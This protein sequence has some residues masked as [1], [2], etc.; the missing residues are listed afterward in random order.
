MNVPQVLACSFRGNGYYALNLVQGRKDVRRCQWND[1]LDGID[2]YA[3]DDVK[4]DMTILC[5]RLFDYV[6]VGYVSAVPVV[7]DPDA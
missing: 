3:L 2:I 7:L 4:R 6:F 5:P 1:D